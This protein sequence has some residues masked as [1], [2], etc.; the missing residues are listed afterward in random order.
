MKPILLLLATIPWV[1]LGC[2]A[3]GGSSAP[4]WEQKIDP[5]LR[6]EM[7]GLRAQG[8]LLQ[9]LPVLIKFKSP[10]SPEQE[11]ELRKTGVRVLGQAGDVATAVVA[12]EAIS[13]L[14]KRDYVIYLEASKERTFKAQQHTGEHQ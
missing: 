6:A 4:A 12:P 3:S 5:R 9:G 1:W 8:A 10:L 2:A 11:S 13:E 7:Q 14:A